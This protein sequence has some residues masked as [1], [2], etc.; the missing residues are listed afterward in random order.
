MCPRA[1]IVRSEISFYVSAIV[2]FALFQ[3][4]FFTELLLLVL[5]CVFSMSAHLVMRLLLAAAWFSIASVHHSLFTQVLLG[6]NWDQFGPICAAAPAPNQ[7]LSSDLSLARL[8]QV[9]LQ[10]RL[11]WHCCWKGAPTLRDSV[12]LSSAKAVGALTSCHGVRELPYITASPERP[13]INLSTL[14]R[15]DMHKLYHCYCDLH[16]PV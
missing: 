8:V 7:H 3:D 6:S 2:L 10:N 16:F 15:S 4:L 12:N 5:C 9:F 13:V 11:N 1:S 14:C